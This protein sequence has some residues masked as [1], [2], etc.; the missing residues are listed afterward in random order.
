MNSH[1]HKLIELCSN[2]S[3]KQNIMSQNIVQLENI[4]IIYQILISLND[5]YVLL[6]DNSLPL[7]FYFLT[8]ILSAFIDEPDVN[9]DE[10]VQYFSHLIDHAQT[11]D[12]DEL[13]EALFYPIWISSSYCVQA[14]RADAHDLRWKYISQAKYWQGIIIGASAEVQGSRTQRKAK[15]VKAAQAKHARDYLAKEKV[16][17][18]YQDNISSYKSLDQAADKISSRDDVP[19]AFS[20]VRKWLGK[21]KKI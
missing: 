5:E 14:L 11:S 19:Y 3:A 6:H 8:D 7:Q 2:E 15:S 9:G 12:Q 13:E 16:W 17:K 1:I 10:K 20:T 21:L 18:I 4:D